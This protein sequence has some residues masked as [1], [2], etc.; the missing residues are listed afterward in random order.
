MFQNVIYSCSA[1]IEFSANITPVLSVTIKWWFGVQETF[2][3]FTVLKIVMLLNILWEPTVIL[4]FQDSLMNR[5]FKRTAFIWNWNICNI[6][7]VCTVTSDQF[8]VSS[9]DKALNVFESINQSINNNKKINLTDPKLLNGD[10][11]QSLKMYN[12]Y[13]YFKFLKAMCVCVYI[14]IYCTYMWPWTT[15]PVLSRWGIF[16]AIAKNTLYG[17]KLLIFLLC[18]KSLG[19]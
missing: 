17:S 19:H 5:K 6:I 7:N 16:V 10:V 3:L 2:V 9:L 8:I 12:I 4:F 13:I 18:Q 1:K 11:W 14:Y 15:K